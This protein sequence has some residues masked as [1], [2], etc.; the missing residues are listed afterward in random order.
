MLSS[1]DAVKIT[2]EPHN[3]RTFEARPTQQKEKT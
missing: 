2:S 3:S 1:D